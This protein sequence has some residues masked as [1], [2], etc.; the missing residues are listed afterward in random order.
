M[1]WSDAKALLRTRLEQQWQA[2][3]YRATKLVFPNE[4]PPKKDA[5][6]AIEFEGTYGDKTIFGSV[7]KRLAV[8][9][10][11]VFIHAFVPTGQG[12]TLGDKL[13]E[14]VTGILELQQI[15]GAG[16]P[17]DGRIALEGGAPP[18]PVSD[19]QPLLKDQPSGSYY[20]VSGSVPFIVIGA[21]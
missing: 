15:A 18:S 10:G 13:V 9:A 5:Y 2:G 17:P 7:G 16:N 4:Y 21:R 19:D 3:Q 11:I 8:E 1:L 14:T 6:V 20:R 12:D